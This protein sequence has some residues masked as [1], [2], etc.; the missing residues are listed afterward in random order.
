MVDA[1]QVTE[2]RDFGMAAI[3]ARRGASAAM[4]GEALRNEES[5]D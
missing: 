4:I 1:V 3:L 2:K 5:S